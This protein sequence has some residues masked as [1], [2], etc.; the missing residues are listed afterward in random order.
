[1]DILSLAFYLSVFSYC[2]G[3]LLRALPIPFFTVKKLGR[4]LV[5]DSVFS[6]I[7]VFSYRSITTIIEYLSSVLGA[8][9]ASYSM[10]VTERTS[11]LLLLLSAFKAIGIV[12]SKIGLGA[13]FSSLIS[14]IINL[15]TTSLTTLLTVTVVAL[16]LKTASS[17]LIALGILL[18]SVPFRLA[19]GAGAMIIAITVVFSIGIPLMPHFIATVSSGTL[20]SPSLHEPVCSAILHIV[21]AK[22]NPIGQAVIEGY[23]DEDFLYRYVFNVNGQLVVDKLSS[24]FPCEEH[25]VRVEISGFRYSFNMPGSSGDM[26]LNYTLLIPDLLVLD[27]RRLVE[28]GSGVYIAE[29]SKLENELTLQLEVYENTYFAVYIEAQDEL[30]VLI[31]GEVAEESRVVQYTWYS[32]DYVGYEYTLTPG[33]Y[34]VNIVVDYKST[35]P[36]DV[37]VEPFILKALQL[38]VLAP[39]TAFF[40]ITYMFVELTILPL[41]Y[42]TILLTITYGVARLLGGVSA[43]I[44]RYLVMV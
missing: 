7:L 9:W 1:M 13:V 32:I 15:I 25:L 35:T 26:S 41:I 14:S 6:A 10:W 42:V 17:F 34:L 37:L 23:R 40:Y 29:Y 16:M 18:I 28:I 11:L 43:N 8:D 24:G 27:T 39:E 33:V 44:A 36:L 22:G 30:V 38:D 5:V 2:L 21:D 3:L 19:R 12:T 20:T 31:N 4:L